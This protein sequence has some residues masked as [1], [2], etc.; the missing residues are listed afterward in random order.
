MRPTRYQL[1]YRRSVSLFDIHLLNFKSPLLSKLQFFRAHN[2]I[3]GLVVEYIVAIDVTRVR[4]PADALA[5]H[6]Y[7]TPLSAS[8]PQSSFHFS[9]FLE[10]P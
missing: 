9:S 5:L 10:S 4:F 3:S 2:S 7:Q 6:L 8:S 1:R